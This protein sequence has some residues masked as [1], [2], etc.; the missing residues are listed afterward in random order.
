MALLNIQ[1]NSLDDFLRSCSTNAP[2]GCYPLL[3][4]SDLCIDESAEKSNYFIPD[5]KFLSAHFELLKYFY[6]CFRHREFLQLDRDK[7]VLALIDGD[8]PLHQN[9]FE[10]N[11]PEPQQ[12][13]LL[14]EPS[15]SVFLLAHRSCGYHS[16]KTCP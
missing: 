6:Y 16:K 1:S 14:D 9:R 7:R 15:G 10:T 11:Q 3:S 13:Q 8:W 5:S 2:L 12:R 4:L